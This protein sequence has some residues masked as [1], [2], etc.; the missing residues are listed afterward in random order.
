M[1]SSTPSYAGDL[2]YIYWDTGTIKDVNRVKGPVGMV[3]LQGIEDTEKRE[4]N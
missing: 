3:S 4:S 2:G 1:D